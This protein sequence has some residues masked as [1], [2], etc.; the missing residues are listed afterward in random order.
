MGATRTAHRG[1]QAV[2][3][4]LDGVRSGGCCRACAAA[5]IR[6]K[7]RMSST[8]TYGSVRG[9]PGDRHPYRDRTTPWITQRQSAP[10]R[11][12]SNG[13]N[14]GKLTVPTI[15]ATIEG[16]EWDEEKRLRNIE[17]HGVDFLDAARGCRP[18]GGLRRDP[19]SCSRPRRRQLF[20]GRLCET[21]RKP[22]NYQRLENW[23]EWQ[24]KISES[25]R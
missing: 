1:G 22:Q 15:V 7:S 4:A 19:L 18:S 11:W 8:L 10:R 13:P 12:A 5:I 25:T 23:R 14:Q 17:I 20:H 24:T 9:V 6:G 16:V 21:R 3:Q 2:P